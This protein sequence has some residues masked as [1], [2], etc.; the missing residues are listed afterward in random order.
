[1]KSLDADHSADLHVDETMALTKKMELVLLVLGSNDPHAIAHN[2]TGLHHRGQIPSG[3]FR[4]MQ[5]SLSL[6]RARSA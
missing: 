6:R 4:S 2:P 1:M 5:T 3:T